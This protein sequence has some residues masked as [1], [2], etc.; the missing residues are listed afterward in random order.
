MRKELKKMEAALEKFA[1]NKLINKDPAYADKLRS[2]TVGRQDFVLNGDWQR[3]AIVARTD[4]RA[5]QI[6]KHKAIVKAENRIPGCTK[7]DSGTVVQNGQYP[8]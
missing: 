1:K 6:R 5:L 7:I 3:F 8:L 2:D 4:V